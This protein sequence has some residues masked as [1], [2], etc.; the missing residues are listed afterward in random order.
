MSVSD[1]RWACQAAAAYVLGLGIMSGPDS[2]P[3]PL[4]GVNLGAPLSGSG[5]P[6]LS[7]DGAMIP[8]AFCS[9]D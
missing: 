8:N 1:G 4:P 5:A 6:P 3:L 2:T 9:R 7:P